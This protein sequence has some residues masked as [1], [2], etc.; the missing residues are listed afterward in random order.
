[1]GSPCIANAPDPGTLAAAGCYV[2]SNG[3]SVIV[4]PVANTYGTMG[5]GIFRDSGFKNVDFS[6][7][8]NFVFKERFNATFRV[9][10]FNFFN[11]PILA[12]PYSFST[13][14]NPAGSTSF[15]C[16]C[17]TPDVAAGNSIVGSG[18]P[19]DLQLGFKL[20]F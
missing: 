5:R 4:P 18:A 15:G 14:N 7:F 2:S 16:G 1:M 13:G 6:I 12:N 9:E 11:H 20:A 10:F 19:R 8:K 3:K 17:A